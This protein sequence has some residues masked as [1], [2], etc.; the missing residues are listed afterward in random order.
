MTVDEHE[1]ERFDRAECESGGSVLHDSD[2]TRERLEDDPAPLAMNGMI[3]SDQD[4]R[5]RLDEVRAS[6]VSSRALKRK[7]IV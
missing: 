1:V 6:R 4:F 5:L 7:A 3:V 2:R